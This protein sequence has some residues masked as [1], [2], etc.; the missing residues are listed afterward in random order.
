MRII[1]LLAVSLSL[2]TQEL[3]A[4][5][6][7]MKMTKITRTQREFI[8]P[9]IIFFLYAKE[10]LSLAKKKKPHIAAQE[11]DLWNL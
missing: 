1:A 6:A 2:Y 4:A 5:R 9:M 8:T 11:G 10:S 7:N 3:T